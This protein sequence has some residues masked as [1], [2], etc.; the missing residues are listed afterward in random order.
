MPVLTL[1]RPAPATIG[2]KF[3]IA[4]IGE[5][6]A[7]IAA[8][9][10]FNLVNVT[11]N[12]GQGHA[13]GQAFVSSAGVPYFLRGYTVAPSPLNNS[14]EVLIDEADPDVMQEQLRVILQDLGMPKLRFK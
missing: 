7:D 12:D 1:E 13:L 14:T 9:Q 8:R 10:G 6:I 3:R 11:K 4:I 5:K 2:E